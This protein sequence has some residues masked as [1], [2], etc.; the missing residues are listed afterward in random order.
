MD[1]DTSAHEVI[2]EALTR[3]N[4]NRQEAL[5]IMLDIICDGIVW[6]DQPPNEALGEITSMLAKRLY[7]ALDDDELV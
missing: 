4:C 6:H 1:D 7:P 5:E 2:C 3:F